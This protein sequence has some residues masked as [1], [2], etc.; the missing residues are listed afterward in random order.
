LTKTPMRKPLSLLAIAGSAITAL[1]AAAAGA[2][3]SHP[4]DGV[5]VRELLRSATTTSGDPITLPEGPLEAVVARYVIAPR[6]ALPVHKHPYV[7]LGYVLSG[8]LE[9][10]NVQTHRSRVFKAGE[11]I[12][13]DIGQWHRARNLQARSVELLVIDLTPVGR[14]NTVQ[15]D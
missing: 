14:A 12:V 10:T 7:R 5:D 8:S 6:A 1:L 13:E 4:V 3:W 15:R 2:A 9:V 11:V